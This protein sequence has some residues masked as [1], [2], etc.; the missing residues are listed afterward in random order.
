MRKNVLILVCAV[1]LFSLFNTTKTNFMFWDNPEINNDYII[2][3]DIPISYDN[4]ISLFGLFI[5]FFSNLELDYCIN[6]YIEDVKDVKYEK[7]KGE[8]V[9]FED[10]TFASNSYTLKE[11]SFVELDSF[12]SYLQMN[13]DLRI[14]IQGHT[15]DLGNKRDNQAL[16]K[17]RAKSVFDYLSN[18]VNNSLT[19]KGY[20]ESQPLIEDISMLARKMNRRTSFIYLEDDS[21]ILNDMTNNLKVVDDDLEEEIISIP[22]QE[23]KSPPPSK[24][25]EVI[26]IAEY[27][28]KIE[29]EDAESD[30]GGEVEI[31]EVEEDKVSIIEGKIEKPINTTLNTNKVV[32]NPPKVEEKKKSISLKV[33]KV[34]EQS[35]PSDEELIMQNPN[36]KENAKRLILEALENEEISIEDVQ[37]LLSE[38]TSNRKK[39]KKGD[40]K[41]MI[42]KNKKRN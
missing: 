29:I 26:E 11:T 41:D 5:N 16:S 12:I 27:D 38:H 30:E 37:K 13:P 32:D 33:N 17:K 10:V 40:V 15:D 4:D 31:I 28:V 42:K 14:E 36:I 25:T 24:L 20:G 35:L 21:E 8:E 2:P 7:A 22:K 1:V 18:Q 34:I 39:V 3:P 23:V 6:T 9:V 19:Y